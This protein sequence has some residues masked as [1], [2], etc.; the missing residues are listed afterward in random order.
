MPRISLFTGILI[1][2]IFELTVQLQYEFHTYLV[3]VEHGEGEE[4]V[5]ESEAVEAVRLGELQESNGAVAFKFMIII[6]TIVQR[7]SFQ[8]LTLQKFCYANITERYFN[9][10]LEILHY[11]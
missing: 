7:N 10:K 3:E 9:L 6:F 1:F 11:K 8:C 5:G 4:G 2:H